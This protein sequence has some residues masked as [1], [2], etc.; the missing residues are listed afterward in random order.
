[1]PGLMCSSGVFVTNGRNK[2][3]AFM[4]ADLNYDVWIGNGRGTIYSRKH[5]TLDPDVDNADFFNFT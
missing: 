5:V 1:M 3:L 4:L 2:S